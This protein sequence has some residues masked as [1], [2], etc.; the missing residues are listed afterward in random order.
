MAA[1]HLEELVARVLALPTEDRAKLAARIQASLDEAHGNLT[2]A[3]RAVKGAPEPTP[4]PHL[5]DLAGTGKGLWGE[6]SSAYLRQLRD[7]WR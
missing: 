5:L 3:A 7:E 6:D 1:T 4:T 2:A